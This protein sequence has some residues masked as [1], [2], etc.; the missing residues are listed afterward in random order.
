MK[1]ATV[2]NVNS[3]IKMVLV[4]IIG[5]F[6]IYSVVNSAAPSVLGNTTPEIWVFGVDIGWSASL[7]PYVLAAIIV[8]GIIFFL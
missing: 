6:L 8:L 4:A 7:I 5:M 3:T 1:G 2:G